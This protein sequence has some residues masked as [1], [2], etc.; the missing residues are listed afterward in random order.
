ME[1][2]YNKLPLIPFIFMAIFLFALQGAVAK[3]GA[4]EATLLIKTS[5]I[6]K[7]CK[8]RLESMLAYE[9]GV[10][11]SELNVDTKV[12]SVTYKSNKTTP[13]KIKKSITEAGYDADELKADPKAYNKLPRCCKKE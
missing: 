8:D 10:V 1:L 9:K 12:L 6:C 7:E 2:K 5:A 11:K 13:E 3:G 4:T